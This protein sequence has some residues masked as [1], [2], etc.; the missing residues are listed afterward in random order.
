MLAGTNFIQSV[1]NGLYGYVN[2]M[3]DTVI[4]CEY[5]HA[6]TDSIETL[7]FVFDSKKKKSLASITRENDYST[8]LNMIMVLIIYGTDFSVYE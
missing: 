4:A 5:F 6:Y 7:G 2:A 8:F 3:N 1:T